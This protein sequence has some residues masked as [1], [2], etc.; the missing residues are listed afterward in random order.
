MMYKR[1]CLFL[2][3]LAI[4]TACTGQGAADLIINRHKQ[5]LINTT[6]LNRSEIDTIINQYDPTLAR[7]KNINY[8]LNDLSG[9]QITNHLVFVKYL[10]LF[11]TMQPNQAQRQGVLKI[12]IGALDEWYRCKFKNPNWW[13]NEIG[14]PQLM[15]DIIVLLRPV[16]TK[17]QLHNYLEIVNQYQMKGTGANLIWS[18]DIA[19]FYGLFTENDTLVQKATDLIQNEIRIGNG[20]GLK[21]DYS[22][23]QHGARLQMYQ[24]GKVFLID[25]IR[26]AWELRETQWKYP[27]EKIDLLSSMLLLGWQWMARGVNT[28]PET[29]DRSC[30]RPDALKEPDIR[31]YISY[32]MEMCPANKPGF[33]HLKA[34]QEGKG[35]SLTGF[36]TYPFSD[37]TTY[38][39]RKYSFFLKTIS[40]RTLPTESIN[41]ENL[42][43]RL[44]NSGETYFIRRGNEYFN[45]MPIW[46][47]EKLPGIT[48]FKGSDRISRKD[49]SGSLSDGV[50]GFSTMKY[51]M[52]AKDTAQFLSCNKSWFV[53]KNLMICLLG[54]IEISGITEA[55]TVLN[56]TRL[57]E[58]IYTD[59]GL[60]PDGAYLKLNNRFIYHGGFAYMPLYNSEMSLYADT[61]S[62]SWFNI[63]HSYS[64][65]K[66]LEKVF[67]PS[68]NHSK[69]DKVGGYAV[70]YSEKKRGLNRK[71]RKPSFEIIANNEGC[72]AILYKDGT[73][74]S[75]F[76][77]PTSLVFNKGVLEVDQ[78]CLVL[79]KKGH[80]FMSDP[81]HQGLEVNVKFN[82]AVY[83]A[84]LLKDGA[85]KQIF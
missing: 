54:D 57:T 28:I 76:F 62:G 17:N 75:V 53:T 49:F 12:I 61:L 56:Q 58:S 10:G 31:K 77:E 18:A 44:L 70:Y 16:L 84:F 74:M 1:T 79:Y 80:L 38:H 24:Y 55:Y 82:E 45:L 2:F 40:S 26:L 4:T 36:R 6:P 47:W 9:W 20:D 50:S 8:T 32:F 15:R 34:N 66:I 72:Q 63:N 14:T 33:A 83:T 81:S 73:M 41:F 37:I 52:V 43:G 11:W 48:A 21:P 42:K 59:K 5:F 67:I 69:K 39:Q 46:D 35:Y 68:I 29:M 85:T 60:L 51:K 30:S 22:F 27:S 25:N 3:L 71:I 78:P 19:L 7:W 65:D 13:H 23:H 64:K